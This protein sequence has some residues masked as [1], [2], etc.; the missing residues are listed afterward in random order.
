MP[1][2][3]LGF[4]AHEL[5]VDAPEVPFVQGYSGESKNRIRPSSPGSA[6]TRLFAFNHRSQ[7]H[8]DML[9]LFD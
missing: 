5:L 2:I 4:T 8:I 3:K 6:R 1:A 9:A 7:E